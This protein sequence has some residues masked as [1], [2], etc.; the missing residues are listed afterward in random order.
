MNENR[1]EFYASDKNRPA[2]PE[3]TE[4]SGWEK[5]HDWQAEIMRPVTDW[6]VR[7]T[8]ARAGQRI[9]DVACGSGLPA[10]ALAER[11][12][13]AGKVLA[14]D[15]S[16]KMLSATRRKACKAFAKA[17]QGELKDLSLG[18]ARLG[19]EVESLPLGDDPTAAPPPE[20][21]ADRVE[22]VF[23]PNPGEPQR[24][25][26]KIASGGELSRVTLAIKSVLAGAETQ[27]RLH[28]DGAA[29]RLEAL[30]QL[31]KDRL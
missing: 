27:V 11:V 21:G 26:R 30:L 20:D 3:R 31:R 17:V 19:V 22:I 8:G 18:A 29:R 12:G 7:A 14:I 10:L 9:L 1:L 24:P 25:L 13:E 2:T 5:W 6:Y 4:V 23:A 16:S 28:V 15:I